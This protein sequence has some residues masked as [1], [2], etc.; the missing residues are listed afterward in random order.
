MEPPAARLPGEIWDRVID[1]CHE[2]HAALDACALV[3]HSWLASARLHRFH[4]MHIFWHKMYTATHGGLLALLC[5]PSS[6]APF[7]VRS[8][9]L[10][11]RESRSAHRPAGPL[12]NTALPRMRCRDMTAL[13][14]LTIK[15]AHW[16][17]VT[18]DAGE[19]CLAQFCTS[20]QRLAFVSP[21]MC[22]VIPVLELVCAAPV[23]QTFALYGEPR[24]IAQGA[25]EPDV[26]TPGRPAGPRDLHSPWLV[27]SKR[28]YPLMKF[29]PSFGLHA[30]LQHLHVDDIRFV[31]GLTEFIRL[32]ADT[33]KRL[34]LSFARNEDDIT[35]FDDESQG[36]EGQSAHFQL[37]RAHPV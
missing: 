8:L 10:E 26:G 1:H 25:S 13:R 27:G 17:L 29:I 36:A 21:R 4:S 37:R 24:Y 32:V 19:A 18:P 12:L 23:L 2:D 14:S 28:W 3:C 9:Y 22:S 15:Y 7:Y 11:E 16:D 33:L 35:R 30:G 5:D 6:S 34:S 31:D 20:L